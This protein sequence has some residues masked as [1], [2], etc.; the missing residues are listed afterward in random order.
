MAFLRKLGLLG[1][2]AGLSLS[3]RDA[4]ACSCGVGP[5]TFLGGPKLKLPANA[6][7]VVYWNSGSPWVVES[8]GAKVSWRAVPEASAF[9]IER[10]AAPKA[11]IPHRLDPIVEAAPWDEKGRAAYAVTLAATE[12][13][14]P[15]E[16]RFTGPDEA[17]IEVTIDAEPLRA[18]APLALEVG[19]QSD[20]RL[21][22]A[23]GVSCSAQVPAAW[24][25][26]GIAL[27]EAFKRYADG[28]LVHTRV[29]GKIWRP[30]ESLCK[31][32]APGRSYKGLGKE[33]LYSVC[34]GPAMQDSLATGEHSV[35]VEVVVPGGDVFK[36]E[37]K[38]FTLECKAGAPGNRPPGNVPL[39]F[40]PPGSG[41]PKTP[42]APT[43]GAG[44]AGAGSEKPG[45]G[46][47]AV[48]DASAMRNLD[49]LW[50]LCAA[51]AWRARRR[52]RS[53]FQ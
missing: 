25:P 35:Q 40:G 12:P 19:P 30:S 34:A 46:K 10:T 24:R 41:P 53:R 47:C 20:S 43:P 29:D 13:L 2:V 4:Q 33:V 36:S 26:L 16:Y 14:T 45:C 27:P 17:S 52:R 28:L 11:K 48:G 1:L 23:M 6:R 50:L 22:V 7:G 51:L 15:G 31:K 49:G 9:S 42:A 32:P 5:P 44:S 39:E 3:A 18:E 37:A 21:R 8:A 38:K